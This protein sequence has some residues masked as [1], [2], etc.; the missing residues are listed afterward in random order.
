M[1]DDIHPDGQKLLDR[2]LDLVPVFQELLAQVERRSQQKAADLNRVRELKLAYDEARRAHVAF[3]VTQSK[4]DGN[5]PEAVFRHAFEKDKI[6][7]A[8]VRAMMDYHRA[9]DEFFGGTVHP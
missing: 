9:C 1:T 8:S 6:I 5:D 7:N 3:N 4:P 2:C